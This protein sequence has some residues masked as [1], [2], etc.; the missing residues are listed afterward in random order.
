MN[1]NHKMD[2]FRKI[3]NSIRRILPTAT[4]FTDIIV[5]FT[6][7]TDDQFLNTYKAMEEIRFNMAYIA[8]YSPRPGAASSR[9][10][11]DIPFEIKKQRLHSLSTLLQSHSHI[12]NLEMTGKTYKVLVINND[13]KDGYLS[14]VT[15]GK[16]IVRF[17]ANDRVLTG[18]FVDV[19]ITSAADFSVEGELMKIYDEEPAM[20]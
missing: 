10:N 19:K 13:R 20:V 12:L 17:A 11:D 7:E 18:C 8:R 14:G 2:D 16:I 3:V 15:E 4:L 9:W 5:G 6:G 1:R